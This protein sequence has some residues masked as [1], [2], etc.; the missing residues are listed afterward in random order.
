MDIVWPS[1]KSLSVHKFP[2]SVVIGQLIVGDLFQEN[3]D[4]N[5]FMLVEHL[6]AGQLYFKPTP[7]TV[8]VVVTDHTQSF[9]AGVDGILDVLK[10]VHTWFKVPVMET[11]LKGKLATFF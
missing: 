8:Q 6:D 4:N 11:E 5:I 7:F 3:Q 1:D 9:P 2:E 10:D